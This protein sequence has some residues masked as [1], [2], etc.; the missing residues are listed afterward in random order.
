[1]SFEWTCL[2]LTRVLI[3]EIYLGNMKHRFQNNITNCLCWNIHQPK[4]TRGG[5]GI[6]ILILHSSWKAWPCERY[7]GPTA[8]RHIISSL[9]TSSI[10]RGVARFIPCR[11]TSGEAVL[12]TPSPVRMGGLQCRF[13]CCKKYK[14]FCPYR[15]WKPRLPFTQLVTTMTVLYACWS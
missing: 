7:Y 9:L 2:S 15:D 10:D 1:M 4:K 12:G 13:Q 11:F 8:E 3:L 6:H 14:D 5:F